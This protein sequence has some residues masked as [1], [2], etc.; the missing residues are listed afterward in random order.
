[1]DPTGARAT[2]KE[3]EALEDRIEAALGLEVNKK[4]A[5]EKAGDKDLEFEA[6]ICALAVN[7]QRASAASL[8]SMATGDL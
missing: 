1:L 4:G 3:R 7:S 6:D 2:K 5:K 8:T